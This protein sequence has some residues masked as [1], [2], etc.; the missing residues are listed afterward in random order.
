MQNS[1]KRKKSFEATTT[2]AA[3]NPKTKK[4]HS[5]A[6]F[7]S[8]TKEKT[9]TAAELLIETKEQET[10]TNVELLIEPKGEEPMKSV[11]YDNSIYTDELN[12]MLETV[13][14]DEIFLFNEQ[15]KQIFGLFRSLKGFFFF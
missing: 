3:A 8:Q 1:N 6:N 9:E 7:F 5:I 11:F 10:E 12:L 15:E 13:L 14:K 2:T 4:Q